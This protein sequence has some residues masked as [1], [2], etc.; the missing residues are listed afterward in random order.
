MTSGH[1]SAHIIVK[2][3]NLSDFVLLA[4]SFISAFKVP[5]RFPRIIRPAMFVRIH[6]GVCLF[7]ESMNQTKTVRF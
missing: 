1:Y 5:K 6:V 7:L 2:M 3:T 4:A